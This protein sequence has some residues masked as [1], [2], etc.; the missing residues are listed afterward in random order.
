MQRAVS[1]K[2]VA[3]M[4]PSSLVTGF[5]AWQRSCT[6]PV[7][8]CACPQKYWKLAFSSSSRNA[9]SAL[10]K[11]VLVGAT[12]D[13]V[14]LFFNAG[15][16]ARALQCANGAQAPALA[17]CFNNCR[18]DIL[19]FPIY[20]PFIRMIINAFGIEGTLMKRNERLA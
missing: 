1:P 9:S 19:P 8:G 16:S 5:R 20:I 10:E 2:P 13:L 6:M 14:V 4:L 3:A 18:R 12:A 11:G 15:D 7:S 17:I